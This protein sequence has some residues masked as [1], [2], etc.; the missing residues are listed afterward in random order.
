MYISFFCFK[1][2]VAESNLETVM[3]HNGPNIDV[4]GS[5]YPV[6]IAAPLGLMAWLVLL[7]PFLFYLSRHPLSKL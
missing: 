6:D 2:L 7:S 3:I 4:S 1:I 5:W